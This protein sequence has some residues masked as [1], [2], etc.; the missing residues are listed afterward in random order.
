ML[1]HNGSDDALAIL[2]WN[3]DL[4]PNLPDP[5]DGLGNAYI[6]LGQFEKAVA[7]YRKAVTACRARQQPGPF[8]PIY[9]ARIISSSYWMIRCHVSYPHLSPGVE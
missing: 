1:N 2:Q 9:P 4:Y 6:R 7:S 3:C 5:C 8:T